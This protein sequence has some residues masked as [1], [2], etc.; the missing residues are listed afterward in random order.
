MAR[1]FQLSDRFD[2]VIDELKPETCKTCKGEGCSLCRGLGVV[3]GEKVGEVRF[4]LGPLSNAQKMELKN[5]T[6]FEGGEEKIDTIGRAIK[7]ISW[8]VKGVAGL[9]LDEEK[10]KPYLLAKNEKGELTDE[11]VGDLLNLQVGTELTI[12]CLALMG[13]VPTQLAN[14]PG[15]QPLKFDFVSKV[16]NG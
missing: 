1:I 10:K 6:K 7:A 8:T 4:Q 2:L 11:C 13:G 5:F 3:A 12:G 9:Y 16:P 14:L 15:R